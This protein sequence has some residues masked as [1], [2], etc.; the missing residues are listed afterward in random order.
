MI[1]GRPREKALKLIPDLA[2]NQAPRFT[3][4][5]VYRARHDRVGERI[6]EISLDLQKYCGTRYAAGFL[7]E[8]D[9]EFQ[10]ALRVLTL[11][12]QRR[13]PSMD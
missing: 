7:N 11:C 4:Y 6:V 12:G 10:V 9:V 8:N 1:I 13:L 5:G 2:R 3:Q